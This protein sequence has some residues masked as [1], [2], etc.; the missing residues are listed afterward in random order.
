MGNELIINVTLGET[1]VARLENG[2]VAELNIERT[3]EEGVVG[4]IYK[5][6]VARVMAGM[7]AAF[8]EIGL[9]RTAFLHAGDVV[10]KLEGFDLGE[11]KDI[12]RKRGY[13]N[14]RA[15]EN[16]LKDGAEI[17]VQVEK[18]AMG[19]KGARITSHISIPG[20]YLVYMPTLK[21]IGMSRRISDEKERSRLRK[22]VSSLNDQGG[23][24][25]RTVSEGAPDEALI[26]D[27]KYLI[28]LW[29]EINKTSLGAKTPSLIHTDLDVISRVGR[30]LITV[31]ISKVVID[32]ESSAEKLNAFIKRYMPKARQLVE[33][34]NGSEPLFDAYGIEIEITRALGQKVWLKSGGYIVIENTEALTAIDVNTGKFVGKR[35]V[36]DTILKTNLE[37]VKEIVYQLKLRS[38]G[39]II[40]IDFIDMEKFSNRIKVYNALKEALKVD[41]ARTTI[42]K[43]SELGLVEMTRKRTR[44]DIKRQL[45]NTC[46]Y[47]EGKGYLK[48]PT[49][50]CY[51]IFRELQREMSHIQSKQVVVFC[52]PSVANVM[53]D[54]ERA[55][56]EMLENKYKKR[57]SIKETP[58]YHLEQFDVSSN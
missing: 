14:S 52:H 31:D 23:F 30:D 34:Y 36:E 29:D 19:T 51:E 20:R 57:I 12:K 16:I 50:L 4:N 48:S 49:T 42:T 54:E 28:N 27:A 37:A 45:T 21:H 15:I 38:I 24:I 6:K 22:I 10:E 58:D 41:K 35:D 56:L 44:D 3:R 26:E 1:R 43:I 47:C 39:G 32:D 55:W 2:V 40:I 25:I 33:V 17:M 9:D 46:P 11:D 53:Y 8:V 7:Q 18:E 13:K 5:G